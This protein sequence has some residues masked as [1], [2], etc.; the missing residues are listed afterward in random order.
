MFVKVREWF[1]VS[2]LR[3]LVSGW[4]SLIWEGFILLFFKLRDLRVLGRIG[5]NLL[6][7]LVLKSWWFLVL[8]VKFKNLSFLVVGWLVR[9]LMMF[10]VF[11]SVYL[12][13]LRCVMWVVIG[14]VVRVVFVIC[15][16]VI[17]RCV[18]WFSFG[19]M[20]LSMIEGR[21]RYLCSER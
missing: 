21:V 7:F 13:R 17:L 12:V 9:K 20:V 4:R 11:K 1:M 15:V 16:F 19:R 6:R 5:S 18:R 10:L 3:C 8:V 14:I 2:F